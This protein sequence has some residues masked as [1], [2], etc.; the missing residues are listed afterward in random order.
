MGLVEF[1]LFLDTLRQDEYSS[2]ILD[3]FFD[4]CD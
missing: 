2:W 4:P 1:Y 3:L